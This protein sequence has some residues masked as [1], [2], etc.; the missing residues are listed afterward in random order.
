MPRIPRL[1]PGS[2][3]CPSWTPSSSIHNLYMGHIF[4]IYLAGK[5]ETLQGRERKGA[6]RAITAAIWGI[7][8]IK[9]GVG[10]E[11]AAAAF[12]RLAN[13]GL[14][15]EKNGKAGLFGSSRQSRTRPL[16]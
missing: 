14:D 11:V 2:F 6:T 4:P 10:R 3:F 5:L 7:I 1:E 12:S 15:S 13:T 9:T 16:P 8:H